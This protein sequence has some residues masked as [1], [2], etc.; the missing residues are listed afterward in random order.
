[1]DSLIPNAVGSAFANCISRTFTHPL[2]LAKARLQA[3]YDVSS[4]A[5]AA[6]LDGIAT[7]NNNKAAPTTTTTSPSSYRGTLD[8]LQKTFQSE[9]ILGLYRG[10]GAVIVGGTP[11]TILYFC[12]YE[13]AKSK[14][15]IIM[16]A[17]VDLS[18]SSSST[19]TEFLVHFVCG[20]LAE[21]VSCIVFVPV[22]VTKE[23]M[24]IQLREGD[25]N[26]R[27]AVGFSYRNSWDALKQIS[28]TE[29]LSGV[30]KGYLA[31]LGS[32]GPFSAFY[33]AFYEKFKY[34]ARIRLTGRT[35]ES[36]RD[37]DK[38]EI[39]FPWIV[40]C[41]SS[42]AGISAWLTSPL[43]MAKLRLQ[44]QRGNTSRN[45]EQTSRLIYNGVFDCLR[46]TFRDTGVFGLFRG[47]GAR[48]LFVVPATTITMAS[49]ETCRSLA[50]KAL[51]PSLQGHG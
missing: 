45:T 42:A 49:Y 33:F 2:D 3:V 29:G 44:V 22:D 17:E 1:M 23:R 11:A 16:A 31:T 47:A 21:A 38:V 8:V 36:M 28:R 40:A 4:A 6:N 34:W 32:F 43:D 14:L 35:N 12:S 51:P 26:N 25:M 37:L 19:R 20:M 41:S 24:Q 27:A 15:S 18:S 30:Y 48:V 5:A 50:A 10:Y 39:S 13:I 9:G 7:R 46:K